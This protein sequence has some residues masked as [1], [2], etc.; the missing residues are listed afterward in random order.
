MVGLSTYAKKCPFPYTKIC[1]RAY[2]REPTW[3]NW[4]A[5]CAPAWRSGSCL[6]NSANFLLKGVPLR[7]CEKKGSTAR[8]QPFFFLL[9]LG[10]FQISQHTMCL[11]IHSRRARGVTHVLC[12][13]KG[14]QWQASKG[15]DGGAECFEEGRVSSTINIHTLCYIR[16]SQR[17][18]DGGP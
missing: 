6:L 4:R 11:L 1:T 7:G 12:N 2:T 3:P 10:K 9:P 8:L 17:D 16:Y 18:W 5:P 13:W 14:R 15:A